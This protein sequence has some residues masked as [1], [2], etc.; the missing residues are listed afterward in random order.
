MSGSKRRTAHS[1]LAGTNDSSIVS[2]RSA[3]RLGYFARPGASVAPGSEEEPSVLEYFAPSAPRRPP[4]IK[5]PALLSILG[6][7][8]KKRRRLD[9]YC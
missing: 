9:G 6:Y 3:E 4:L 1:R 2:K 8:L 7:R 5:R